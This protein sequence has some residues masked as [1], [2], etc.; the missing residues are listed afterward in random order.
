[1]YIEKLNCNDLV[2]A[3]SSSKESNERNEEER[4][5][6]KNAVPFYTIIII[7]FSFNFY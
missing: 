7:S 2:A 6:I 4:K 1:M 3:H 5:I